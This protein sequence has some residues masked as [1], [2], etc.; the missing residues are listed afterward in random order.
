MPA[1]PHLSDVPAGIYDPETLEGAESII[2]DYCGW[3]IAPA[4]TETL[5][6][7]GP[8]THHL[9]IP[10]LRIKTITSIVDDGT[11]LAPTDYLWSE[12]GVIEKLNSCWTTKRRSIVIILVHGYDACP[13]A[14]REVWK[15]LAQV[16]PASSPVERE[17]VGQ[18]AVTYGAVAGA[19]ATGIP[20]SSFILLNKYR[21]H[22]LA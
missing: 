22:G 4:I 7:D 17:E 3:H 16:G 12:N 6:L 9:Y 19:V 18:V 11:T 15:Q 1:I 21:R 5:T 8:G 14:V 10:S 2:R 20:S 13:P